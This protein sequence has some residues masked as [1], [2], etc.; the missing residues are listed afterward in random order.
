[1]YFGARTVVL[2]HPWQKIYSG[3]GGAGNAHKLLA[4]DSV[5]E[6]VLLHEQ[7]IVQSYKEEHKS[8]EAK[9]TGRGG[10][11]NIHKKKSVVG[12]DSCESAHL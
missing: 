12:S 10:H 5:Y 3:R 1:V 9:S 8:K 11:G 2:S 4:D 6:R 7:G